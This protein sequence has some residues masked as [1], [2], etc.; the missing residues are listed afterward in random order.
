MPWT[1]AAFLVGAAAIC[2]LPPLNGFVSEFL[3]YLGAFHGSAALSGAN[4]V[5]SLFAILALALIGGLALACFAKAFGII[6]LGEP[7]GELGRHGKNGNYENGR[8][9]HEAGLAMRLPML[10]LAAACLAIGLFAPRVVLAMTPAV[11]CIVRTPPVETARLLSATALPLSGIV[12]CA[13][14]F[15]FLATLLGWIRL[16]L[17]GR[18]APALRSSAASA[19]GEEPAR[20]GT[21]DCG[22]ARPTARMQYT[23]SS[24]AQPLTDLFRV[25]LGTRRKFT[26]PQGALPTQPSAFHSE[27]PDVFTERCFRPAFDGIAR[28]MAHPRRLQHGRVQLYVLYVALTLVALLI[29]YL[30]WLS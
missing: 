13:A 20:T 30:G 2:G 8:Q 26:P 9:A 24:F 6:F 23:A 16:R 4:A 18:D 10:L 3:I 11:G 29:W 17:A 12:L 27:T 15:L 22:Y 5:A 14:G 19:G 25:F 7:R 28:L 1:G 21:W